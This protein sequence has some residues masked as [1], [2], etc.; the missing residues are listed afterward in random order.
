[1]SP[2]GGAAL[3]A[4]W[5]ALAAVVV[6]EAFGVT[7]VPV[8]PAGLAGSIVAVALLAAALSAIMLRLGRERVTPRA[9]A[10]GAAF[11]AFAALIVQRALCPWIDLSALGAGPAGSLLVVLLPLSQAAAGLV[12][13]PPPRS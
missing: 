2:L 1:M 6:W 4:A 10:R 13:A 5:G 8:E 3:G 7:D 11:A 12:A 9:L